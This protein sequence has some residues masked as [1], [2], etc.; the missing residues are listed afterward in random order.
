MEYEKL[1]SDSLNEAIYYGRHK[2]GLRVFI[3]EKPEFSSTYAMFGTVYGSVDTR[4]RRDSDPVFTEVPEGIA[5]FLEHKLFESEEGDVFSEFSKTGASANA[6]TSFDRTCYLFSCTEEF[7]RSFKILLDFVQSPYFTKETVEKEQGIIGQ[8]IDMY[9]DSAGWRVF[10]NL[11]TA[12]YHNHPVRIDI[13]GTKESIAEIT[14]ELLYKCYR[15]FYNLSNMFIIVA[16]AA[17]QG[18]VDRLIEGGLKNTDTYMVERGKTEEPQEVA[19]PIIEQSLPVSMPMFGIG[20]KDNTGDSSL[21]RRVA[22]KV[23]LQLIA[24]QTSELYTGLLD[25][26]LINDSFSPEYFA[27]ADYAAVMFSGESGDY[28]AV[29]ERIEVKIREMQQNGIDG[30]EFKRIKKLLYGMSVS[31]YNNPDS[32]A[33]ML[34]ECMVQKEMP[35]DVSTAL[36]AI[37]AED[38]Q[39]VLH[40]IDLTKRAVSVINPVK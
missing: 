15:T 10:F 39:S 35:F 24:G 2:S 23:L 16:G 36:A 4:F 3:S 1:V 20:Y 37:T 5:H 32:I 30:E 8:E 19:Q 34:C 18:T 28:A 25:S 27:G 31:V 17:P 11:L 38:V 13:A 7:E 21:H 12:L 26:G 22:M 33:S 29:A 9:R 40:T 6:Y 14:D